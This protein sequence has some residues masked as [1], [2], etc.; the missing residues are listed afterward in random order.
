MAPGSERVGLTKDVRLKDLD[1]VAFLR[2]DGAIALVFMN[3]YR[4]F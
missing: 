3:R 4:C 1:S 2:P